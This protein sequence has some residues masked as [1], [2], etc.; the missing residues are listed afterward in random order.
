MEEPPLV[1][2]GTMS[3]TVSSTSQALSCGVRHLDC[4]ELYADTLS[5][6]GRAI[7]ESGLERQALWITSKLSGLPCGPYEEVKARVQRQCQV[8]GITYVDLLLVHWPGESDVDFGAS[9]DAAVSKCSGA[10]FLANI[11]DAWAN[12]LRLRQDG[13]TR[14]IGVSNFYWGHL[15]ALEKLAPSEPPFANQIFLDATHQEPALLNA[16]RAR[17]IM[18]MAYRALAFLPVV[19]MAGEMGDGT[20]AALEAQA[21]EC[22]TESVQ[23]LVLAWLARKDIVAVISSGSAAHVEANLRAA[24]LA[25]RAPAVLGGE[26]ADGNETVA[27]CGGLDEYAACFRDVAPGIEG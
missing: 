18:P 26:G 20:H 23:Q 9:P 4:A 10:W 12:M 7:A 3:A 22:G 27:M 6:V 19:K 16:M 13:L 25:S 17:A 5:Q 1:A 14:R 8:L 24:A 11:G 15:H 2:Y 21:A